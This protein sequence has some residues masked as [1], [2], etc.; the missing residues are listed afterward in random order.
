[1]PE[2]LQAKR[3]GEGIATFGVEMHKLHVRLIGIDTKGMTKGTPVLI[4]K[5]F[6]I[7]HIDYARS[8]EALACEAERKHD[9]IDRLMELLVPLR[10]L[11]TPN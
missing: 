8:D 1:M 6:E 5:N 7:E 10:D 4:D 9:D 2:F 11:S 3:Q